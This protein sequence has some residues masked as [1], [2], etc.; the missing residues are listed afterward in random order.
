MALA[1]QRQG[2]SI[3]G[4][5]NGRGTVA[6]VTQAADLL[7]PLAYGAQP[8]RRVQQLYADTLN[9][10][11]HTQPPAAGE[12]SCEEARKMLAGLGARD[13][14][15]LN[16]TASY[17]DV[18]DSEA[19]HLLS[20]GRLDEAR[21]KEMEVY[22]LAEKAL[23]H[24]PA[25]LHALADRS[26]AAELIGSLADRQHDDATA[27]DYA[28]RTVQASEDEVRFN[29]SDLGPWQ[30][31]TV[32]LS[33]VADRQFERGEVANAIATLRSL[34]ALEQDKRLPSRLGPTV[35]YQWIQFARLQAA[36]GNAAG[37]AQA[38]KGYERDATEYAAQFD[39]GDARRQLLGEPA[40]S[41][42]GSLELLQGNAQKALDSATAVLPRITAT[43]AASDNI[44][45]TA[46]RDNFLRGNLATATT[47]A[48]RLGRHAQAEAFGR[49][50]LAVPPDVRSE[51]DP[52]VQ[53][54]M[55]RTTLAHAVALQGR[56]DEARKILQPALA[57][58]RQEQQA[59]A[60]G[61]AF[62]HDFGYALYVD[63]I[64]AATDAAGR[65]QR[66]D[67]LKQAA[68]LLDGTSAEA[69]QMAE[70]R[71]VST[72]VASAAATR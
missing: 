21:Q 29:P 61:T 25:D 5:G 59:G 9:Y 24:R 13:L 56:N 36:T 47:A 68:S 11:S 53:K 67:D 30:R 72:L 49:R 66:S 44:N 38:L 60:H 16:A 22:G 58:Y 8:S 12:A 46:M 23:A 15:D 31:W 28:N 19:R 71:R 34:L 64:T 4:G 27:A 33:E 54:S 41:L 1:L 52:L 50:W 45:G 35:W 39:A 7:R 26:W 69:R 10:V 14:S 6:Q 62:R 32:A 20:L 48:L 2:S 40:K 3:V 55:A 17:A 18:T 37:V 42:S 63:A 57:Y 51:D 43:K 70:M 65:A